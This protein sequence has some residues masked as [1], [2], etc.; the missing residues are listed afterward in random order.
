LSRTGVDIPSS[1]S[2]IDLAACT[3]SHAM[4]DEVMAWLL[5]LA[6]KA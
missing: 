1:F 2:R 6:S 4:T 3:E 5:L